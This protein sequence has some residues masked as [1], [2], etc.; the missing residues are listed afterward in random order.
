MVFNYVF[1][2]NILCTFSISF[3]HN[4]RFLAI[5]KQLY[6]TVWVFGVVWNHGFTDKLRI[7]YK[8]VVTFVQSYV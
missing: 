5:T 8:T 1:N 2:F 6:N 4:K 3:V 7:Y